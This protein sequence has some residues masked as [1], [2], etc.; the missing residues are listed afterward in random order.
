MNTDFILRK[1]D[2]MFTPLITDASKKYGNNRWLAY[3][4][5]LK[6][7]V[8]LFSDLE[9]EHW[10][11]LEFDANV[12]SFCEQPLKVSIK[13][14]SKEVSSIF[15]MWV[16]YK[17]GYEE[18]LEIKYTSDLLKENV[19][20]QLQI[21]KSWCEKNLKNH[22][23]VTDQEIKQDPIKNSNM[24]LILNMIKSPIEDVVTIRNIKQTIE[25]T[26][27]KL[28]IEALSHHSQIPINQ[29]LKI[30]S[31][32]IYSNEIKSDYSVKPLGKKTEVWL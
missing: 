3:S 29:T 22:R 4:S 9:Y 28:T 27:Q 7:T 6:R 30:V 12:V 8:Y 20:N 1:D 18:F 19:Q 24:K 2:K 10:L 21:Q 25:V 26:P 13:V 32:L 16:Q 31:F 11:Q 17:D 14:E 5:K 23:V 15:D